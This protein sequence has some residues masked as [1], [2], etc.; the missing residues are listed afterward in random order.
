MKTKLFAIVFSLLWMGSFYGTLHSQTNNLEEYC[1]NRYG[2][3]IEY[4]GSTFT[5]KHM[6]ANNDGVA[7]I[8][9]DGN[10]Q[11]RVSGYFNVMDWPV[12]DEYTDFLDVVKSNS[13]GLPVEEVWSDFSE[14]RFEVILK[15]GPKLHYEMTVL[16]GNHF[17]SLSLEVNRKGQSL[18]DEDA[19]LML[20]KLRETI[21]LNIQS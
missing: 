19:R 9:A 12:E 8:S 15:I 4:P 13:H 16:Q 20:D 17:I 21:K 2:F 18:S 5:S 6:S 1:N 7:L 11:L 10:Y 14:N 3:C